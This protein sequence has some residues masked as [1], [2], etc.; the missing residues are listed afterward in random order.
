MASINKKTPREIVLTHGGAPTYEVKAEEQLYRAVMSNMLW[1]DTFYESGESIADRIKNL[2]PKVEPPRVAQI[3]ID[4][5]S[6]MKL[7]HVPLLIAREMARLDT[8]K[9]LV[10]KLLPEIIQRPDELCEF[11]SLYWAV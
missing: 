1:E 5:R 6:L 3:A 7:R 8:H 10:A 11:L 2:I 9:H 4:A